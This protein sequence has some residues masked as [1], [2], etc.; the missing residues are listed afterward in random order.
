MFLC[1]RFTQ[2][3]QLYRQ[4]QHPRPTQ[5]RPF[6]PRFVAE[7]ILL[8]DFMRKW[9][10]NPK[11]NQRQKPHHWNTHFIWIKGKT[12]NQFSTVFNCDYFP[13]TSNSAYTCFMNPI[14]FR[15]IK[16]LTFIAIARQNNP[17]LYVCFLLRSSYVKDNTHFD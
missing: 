16:E 8:C 1:W 5:P 2:T 9:P 6:E 7:I 15:W 14:H 11:C 3:L 12:N 4:C 13:F 10:A 17:L